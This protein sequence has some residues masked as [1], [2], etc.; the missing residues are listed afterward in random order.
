MLN[1]MGWTRSSSTWIDV[2]RADTFLDAQMILET[3]SFAERVSGHQ[4]DAYEDM[5]LALTQVIKPFVDVCT[6]LDADGYIVVCTRRSGYSQT[7]YFCFVIKPHE[8][9]V[10]ID[11]ALGAAASSPMYRAYR[12]GEIDPWELVN[13]LD[14]VGF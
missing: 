14:Q 10:R 13:A 5:G 2:K 8:I 3:T 11:P 6:Y 12:L 1:V 7:G 4:W 9:S